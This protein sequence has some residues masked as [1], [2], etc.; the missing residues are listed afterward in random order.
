MIGLSFNLTDEFT[1]VRDQWIMKAHRAAGSVA[2]YWFLK[3]RMPLR[4]KGGSVASELYWAKREE[5]YEK[6]KRRIKPGAAGRPHV[7][8]GQTRRIMQVGARIRVMSSR[9]R[10]SA[11]SRLEFSGL[12]PQYRKRQR[13]GRIK[14]YDEITRVS[15]GEQRHMAKL[16]IDQFFSVLR[17][18]MQHGSTRGRKKK[19]THNTVLAD[20]PA[21]A[22]AA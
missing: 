8:S 5:S 10:V 15:R 14:L 12:G 21:L 13:T 20:V 7:W 18:Q 2:L 6:S 17:Y 9:K 4:F 1:G 19:I 3:E 16:Y 22:Q 11:R